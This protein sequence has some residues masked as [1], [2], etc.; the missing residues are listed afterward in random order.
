MLPECQPNKGVRPSEWLHLKNSTNVFWTLCCWQCDWE[1]WLLKQERW[2]FQ[3]WVWVWIFEEQWMVVPV[4]RCSHERFGCG[5]GCH[6]L[7]T[8]YSP[9]KW[10]MSQL[11]IEKRFDVKP[12]DVK[13]MLNQKL[14]GNIGNINPSRWMQFCGGFASICCEDRGM[15][16]ICF[17][18]RSC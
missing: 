12:K 16:S 6:T 15:K 17:P 8:R 1:I 3:G 2:N 18:C 4:Q 9:M 13:Q 11:C 5:W 7:M 10:S 14:N